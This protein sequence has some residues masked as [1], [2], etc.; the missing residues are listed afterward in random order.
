MYGYIYETTNLINGKKY[1]GQSRGKFKPWYFGSGVILKKAIDKYGK[2]NFSVKV[3]VYAKSK[4]E[5]NLLEKKFIDKYNALSSNKFYNLHEG[6]R[7]GD[8]FSG[9]K[10]TKEARQK[11]SQNLKGK[12]SPKK[13][14]KFGKKPEEEIEKILLGAPRREEIIVNGKRYPSFNSASKELHIRIGRPSIPRLIERGYDIIIP[15]DKKY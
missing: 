9:K 3:L 7:G 12:T 13:G 15:G 11:I 8:T 5:L 6:G 2:E 10:H 4:K 1:I 14:M